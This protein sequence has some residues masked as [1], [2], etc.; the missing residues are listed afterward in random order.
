MTAEQSR[1]TRE[2]HDR[3]KKRTPADLVVGEIY[4]AADLAEMFGVP[5]RAIER[6]GIIPVPMKR[7]TRQNRAKR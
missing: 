3:A 4:S 5:V 1:R 2:R 6:G 7:T